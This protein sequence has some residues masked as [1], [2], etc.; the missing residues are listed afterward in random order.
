M[1]NTS[2]SID[3]N[4]NKHTAPILNIGDFYD[5]NLLHDYHGNLFQH[6]RAKLIQQDIRD[7]NNDLV[8][9][10]NMQQKLRPGTIVLV[11]TTL[12]CWDIGTQGSSNARKVS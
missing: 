2:R 6:V 10:W 7:T 8:A 4:S 5:P 11:D 1:Y 9:P 12:V 3:H